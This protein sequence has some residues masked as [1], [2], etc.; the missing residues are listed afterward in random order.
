MDKCPSNQIRF[1][2]K[3]K[4][5]LDNP[6]A[7]LSVTDTVASNDGAT[8]LDFL[9]NRNNRSAWLTT[10]SDDSANTEIIAELTDLR[11]LDTIILVKHNFA[12][13]TLQYWDGVSAWVDFSTPIAVTGNADETTFHQFDKVETSRIRLVIQGTIIPD[14][15][16]RMR[17]FII[18]ENLLS[19][20]LEGWP[21]I[22]RP[23]FNTQKKVTQSL[24]GKVSVTES[25]GGFSMEL[26]VRNYG[27]DADL[28]IIEEIYTGRRG[29]LVWL[30]GGDD[31]KFRFRR[32]GYREEDIYLMRAINDYS[33]EWV[34][35]VYQNGLRITLRMSESLD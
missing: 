32:I 5:D 14:T 13:Y 9:R 2:V 28:N 25:I 18:T 35:G 33:P 26:Q 34:R 20:Q 12:A 31:S 8:F 24:S 17:Q 15:D 16:K 29:V 23:R 19:G 6:L 7:S 4:I 30:S 11:D 1:L 3:N 10:D 21:V 27:I 22:R